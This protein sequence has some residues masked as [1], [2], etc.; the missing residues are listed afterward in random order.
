MP[1]RNSIVRAPGVMAVCPRQ[2]PDHDCP[3][4][5]EFHGDHFVVIF[6]DGQEPMGPLQL[7]R[8][9]RVCRLVMGNR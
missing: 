1:K 3:K 5:P 7:N 8:L 2:C 4:K 9:Q 6:S